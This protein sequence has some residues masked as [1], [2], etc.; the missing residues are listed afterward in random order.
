MNE[1]VI[2]IKADKPSSLV[3]VN[4]SNHQTL[5]ET[6]PQVVTVF[7]FAHRGQK[8][9]KGDAGSAGITRLAA[10]A[11][12]GHRLVMNSTDG[13]LIYASNDV[14]QS[15][16]TILGITMGAAVVNA[17]VDVQGFGLMTEPTWAWVP[18]APIYL[19]TNGLLTQV[20]PSAPTALFS[21][22]V[23]FAISA[24]A[25]FLNLHEAIYIK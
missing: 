3:I 6:K 21:L 10:I 13:G 7:D 15:A 16:Y 2:L 12:G 22:V 1:S 14:A 8:G 25:I 24:T 17:P 4:G 5:V 9:D 11:L 23:G 19:G 20:V 18:N